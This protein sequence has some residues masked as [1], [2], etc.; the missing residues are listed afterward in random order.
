MVQ[1]YAARLKMLSVP[2]DYPE[3]DLIRMINYRAFESCVNN[4]MRCTIM[5]LMAR[6]MVM[7]SDIATSLGISRT[8][9]YRHLHSLRRNGLALYRDGRFYVA[10]RLF[11]VYDTLL[12]DDGSIRLTIYPNRGGFIDEMLGFVFV[13]GELCRCDVCVVRDECLS[14]VKGLAKRLEVKI[15]S[16]KPLEAFKEIVIEVVKRDV[17]HIVRDGYLI[18]KTSEELE[19]QTTA[20]Q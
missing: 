12:S 16:E 7:A 11:L 13:K 10:A 3:I 4:E 6:G 9:I 14:A 15:R 1:N 19:E 8:A 5:S 20:E 17:V 18:V 2:K